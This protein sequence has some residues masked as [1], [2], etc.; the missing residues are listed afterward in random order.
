MKEKNYKKTKMENTEFLIGV[1]ENDVPIPE[2]ALKPKRG[3]YLILNKLEVKQSIIIKKCTV[4]SEKDVLLKTKFAIITWKRKNCEDKQ[5]VCSIVV[6][7]DKGD[8][9]IRVWRTK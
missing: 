1:I 6:L 5:F 3:A 7:N 8:R 9:G 4:A 2:E